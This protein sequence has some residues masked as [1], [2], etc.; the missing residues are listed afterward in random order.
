MT[1]DQIRA[2]IRR[3]FEETWLEG[4]PHVIHETSHAKRVTH[5]PVAGGSPTVEELRDVRAATHKAFSDH[6]V[7]IEHLIVEGNMAAA[8]IVISGKH[9]GEVSGVKP[10]GKEMRVTANG[11]Y[12]IEDGRIVEDWTEWDNLSILQQLGLAPESLGKSIR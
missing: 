3:E 4:K 8:R 5:R 2:L 10:T 6:K 12:R 11:I 1:P 7:R 9:T